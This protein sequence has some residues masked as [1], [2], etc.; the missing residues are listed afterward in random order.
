MINDCIPKLAL[1]IS[2][3]LLP[4]TVWLPRL[5]DKLQ[6]ALTFLCPTLFFPPPSKTPTPK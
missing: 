3:V 2:E 4:A 6:D 5:D 1:E